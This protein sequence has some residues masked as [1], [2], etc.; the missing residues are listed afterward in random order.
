MEKLILNEGQNQLLSSVPG[1][2]SVKAKILLSFPDSPDKS[3]QSAIYSLPLHRGMV[4]HAL[5]PLILSMKL[6]ETSE[7]RSKYSDFFPNNPSFPSEA[8]TH[9]Q[10]TLLEAFTESNT[11][12]NPWEIDDDVS[13][14]SKANELKALGNELLKKQNLNDANLL[15]SM[16][17]NL[18][19]ADSGKSYNESRTLISSNLILGSLK[20]GNAKQAKELAE[21]VLSEEPR[22]VKVLYRKALAEIMLGEFEGAKA[23]LLRARDIEPENRE[24]IEELNG[25]KEKE[26]KSKEKAKEIY[27]KMFGGK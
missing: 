7:Y 26:R 14:L 2:N 4:S 15:Y 24:I 12:R 9:L 6:H 18:I 25:L 1:L 16:G 11:K 10:I 13:R 21:K 27:G 3:G 8:R 19:E 22:L 23:D 17:L 20:C 5:E